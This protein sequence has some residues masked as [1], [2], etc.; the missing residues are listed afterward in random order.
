MRVEIDV[1]YALE[2][3]CKRA[4]GN[5]DLAFG[6]DE[7]LTFVTFTVLRALQTHLFY[8]VPSFTALQTHVFCVLQGFRALKTMYFTCFMASGP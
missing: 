4:H 2:N 5:R 3:T 7:K 1:K 6:L 8:V